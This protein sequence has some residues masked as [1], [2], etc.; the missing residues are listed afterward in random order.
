MMSKKEKS[1][2]L[3]S[4]ISLIVMAIAA[5]FSYGFVQ[6]ELLGKSAEIT[7]QNLA[8]NKYLFLAGITGWIVIIITDL[9]AA[10]GLYIFFKNRSARISLIAAII[11]ILYTLILCAA[12]YQ[13]IGIIPFLQEVKT[14]FEIKSQFA[15]FEKIWSAG[16]ILFGF[17]LLGLGYLSVKSQFVPGFLGYLLYI[18]GASYILIHTAKQFALFSQNVIASVETVLAFPMALSEILLALWLI[19]SGL[20]SSEKRNN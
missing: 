17:H 7:W 13:L 1:A 8:V 9:I 3:I 19:Y 5:G 14:S 18:A 15:S 12:V 20:K 16:L 10:G 6:N 4:G 2:G 11:R